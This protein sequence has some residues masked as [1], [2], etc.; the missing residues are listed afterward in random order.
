MDVLTDFIVVIIS[1]Y[2]MYQIIM[3]Y[4]LNLQNVMLVISQ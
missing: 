1:K 4:S 2:F 3:L